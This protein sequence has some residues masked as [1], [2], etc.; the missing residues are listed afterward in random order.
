[1]G[2]LAVEDW[3]EVEWILVIWLGASGGALEGIRVRPVDLEA[4]WR[5]SKT[6]SAP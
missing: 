1:M 4:G 2:A 3:L 6:W 5:T